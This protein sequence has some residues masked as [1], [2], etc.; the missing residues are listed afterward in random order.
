MRL[1]VSVDGKLQSRRATAASNSGIDR[2]PNRATTPN[3]YL[4]PRLPTNSC[5]SPEASFDPFVLCAPYDLGKATY[6]CFAA[7]LIL[8]FS[9]FFAACVRVII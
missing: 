5:T 1:G 4:F 8:F 6:I 9:A 7:L 3:A 2:Q